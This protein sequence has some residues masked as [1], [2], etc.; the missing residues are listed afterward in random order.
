MGLR[1]HEANEFIAKSSGGH[2]LWQTGP[3]DISTTGTMEVA[4]NGYIVRPVVKNFLFADGS[5]RGPD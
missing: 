3:T 1:V 2:D 4:E 5:C